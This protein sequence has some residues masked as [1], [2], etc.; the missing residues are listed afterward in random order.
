MPT[1]VLCLGLSVIE[2]LCNVF[3]S[4][5]IDDADDNF[6]AWAPEALNV[7][8]P[9]IAIFDDVDDT[10]LPSEPKTCNV[11]LRGK[12][13]LATSTLASPPEPVVPVAMTVLP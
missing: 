11:A 9:Q 4:V 3:A 1:L 8:P 13:N 5:V 7:S 6:S 12:W 10:S 2:K